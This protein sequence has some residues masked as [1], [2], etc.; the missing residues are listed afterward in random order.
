MRSLLRGRWYGGSASLRREQA[1]CINYQKMLRV[2]PQQTE[3]RGK[4]C[5]SPDRDAA[6]AIRGR[7]PIGV[8]PPVLQWPYFLYHPSRAIGF[9]LLQIAL[10]SPLGARGREGK[11]QDPDDRGAECSDARSRR[12]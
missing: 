12:L 8:N 2:A 1:A 4:I 10:R 6:R 9:W 7:R 3:T 11:I 5:V